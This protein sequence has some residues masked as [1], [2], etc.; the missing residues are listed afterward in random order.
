VWSGVWWQKL[1]CCCLQ[2]AAVLPPVGH[3]WHVMLVWRKGNINKNCLCVTVLCTIIMVHKDTSS[4]YRSVDYIGLW[5]YLMWLTNHRPSVLWRCWLGH[6]TRKT[7]SKM[8]YNVS[9]GTLNTTILVN[10]FDV[11]II[12]LVTVTIPYCTRQQSTNS[13]ILCCSRSNFLSSLRSQPSKIYDTIHALRLTQ[14][15]ESLSVS[16]YL[17]FFFSA[18]IN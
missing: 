14:L 10:C 16:F 4:S 15:D 9:S 8:T 5:S 12:V 17:N 2:I 6:V 18:S 13:S 1:P 11:F 7:V 3:I